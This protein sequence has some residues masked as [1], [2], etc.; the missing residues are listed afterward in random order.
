MIERFSGATINPKINPTFPPFHHESHVGTKPKH[1][2]LSCTAYVYVSP[3]SIS[4]P[5]QLEHTLPFKAL[6][7]LFLFPPL[8]HSPNIH[9][10]TPL[11]QPTNTTP[12]LSSSTPVRSAFPACQHTHVSSFISTSTTTPTAPM[13]H[14]T[15]HHALPHSHQTQ[16]AAIP[17]STFPLPTTSSTANTTTQCPRRK[18]P[19]NHHHARNGRY[20]HFA[21]AQARERVE[22]E[23]SGVGDCGGDYEG[24]EERERRGGGRGGGHGGKEGYGWE[25]GVL[26]ARTLLVV[27]EARVM[28]PWC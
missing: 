23:D 17:P 9:P 7:L 19:K 2:L 6:P 27:N 22:K 8:A 11:H 12:H 21:V 3:H 14:D 4:P 10:K 5:H 28:E 1:V 20:E 18:A 15:P 13:V 25:G 24:E 26:V 16:K